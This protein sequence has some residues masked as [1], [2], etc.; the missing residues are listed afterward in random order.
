SVK[1]YLTEV[2]RRE[3]LAE[4]DDRR[5]AQLLAFTINLEH[6]GDILDRSL[7]ELAAKKIKNN[8]N[9]SPEGYAE[10]AEMHRH[11]MEQLHVAVS[12]LMTSDPRMARALIDEKAVMRDLEEAA[13]R[14][15]LQRLREGRTLS[16]E[17]STL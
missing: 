9:F 1:T 7:R 14:N 15:H 11:V 12:V 4:I 16:I 17:T 5:C 10:I 8:L 3:G 2:S 6:A 13:T